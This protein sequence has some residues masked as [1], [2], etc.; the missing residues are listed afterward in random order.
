MPESVEMPAPVSTATR[1]AARNHPA[2]WSSTEL[3]DATLTAHHHPLRPPACEGTGFDLEVEVPAT[4]DVHDGTVKGSFRAITER[5]PDPLAVDLDDDSSR[6]SAD[7]QSLCLP[8][9]CGQGFGPTEIGTLIGRSA[10]IQPAMEMVGQR[11]RRGERLD[12]AVLVARTADV[13][14]DH[15]TVCQ[16]GAHLHRTVRLGHLSGIRD[17]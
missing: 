5:R 11:R 7:D 4:A 9:V 15:I 10:E 3:T 8:P 6:A 17:A 2:T 1:S 14:A 16:E 12:R 13:A